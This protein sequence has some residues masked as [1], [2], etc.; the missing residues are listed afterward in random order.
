MEFSKAM[1]TT[2]GRCNKPASQHRLTPRGHFYCLI[3]NREGMLWQNY[4]N[5]KDDLA[6]SSVNLATITVKYLIKARIPAGVAATIK[7]GIKNYV[8]SDELAATG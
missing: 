3:L 6:F 1:S 8:D 4:M 5:M 2:C 7:S